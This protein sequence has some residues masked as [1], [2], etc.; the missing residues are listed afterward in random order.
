MKLKTSS[1]STRMVIKNTLIFS[2][3]IFIGN[4][5][6]AQTDFNQYLD[7]L[8]RMDSI[9]QVYFSKEIKTES[10]TAAVTFERLVM[11]VLSIVNAPDP[12]TSPVC[13]AFDVT[14]PTNNI[15]PSLTA[16]SNSALVPEM[17]TID[18]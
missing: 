15:L 6:I 13:V 3:I 18:V 7:S 11:D 16:V 1:K 9:E 14:S 17:P 2:I 8:N 10:P 12:V 4:I 5:A